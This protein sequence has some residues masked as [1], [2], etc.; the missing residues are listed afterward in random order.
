MPSDN[1]SLNVRPNVTARGNTGLI[2]TFPCGDY[3]VAA[4]A[5]GRVFAVALGDGTVRLIDSETLDAE[6]I[7]VRAHD[8]AALC[9][10]ADTEKGAFLSGGDDGKLVR[11]TFAGAPE[12]IAEVKGRWIEHVTAHT[13]SGVRAYASGK[14]AYVIGKKGGA[15]RKLTHATSVG[16]LAINPKGKRLAVTHYNG[17]SLWW[18]ASQSAEATRLEWKGSH[19]QVIWSPDGD[20]VM[21]AM[22][23]NSL[24]GWRLSDGEHMRMSGYATKVRS[25]AFSRRGHF[26]ATGGSERVV[27][28]PFT[29]GGPMGKAPTEFGGAGEAFV[30]AVAAHPLH[31]VF[32]AAFDNG[33]LLIGQPG[34]GGV[35]LVMKP[36]GNAVTCLVWSPDGEKLLAGTENGDIHVADFR[37]A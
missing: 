22:Q 14:D 15:A 29:G 7:T 30:T 32:A 18:L 20:Y 12:V 13:G 16:G 10:T 27:C 26:L 31:D 3:A 21:T 19:L 35:R 28:W 6:S 25:M 8:G 5:N 34:A 33:A 4:A 23:E 11:S 9:L 17:V 24:H 2:A 1:I 36:N 37:P